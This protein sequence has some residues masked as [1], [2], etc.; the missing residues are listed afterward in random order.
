MQPRDGRD[1]PARRGFRRA[2][3]FAKDQLRAAGGRRGFAETEVL[4]RWP[5]IVGAALAPLCRPVKVSYGR[6]RTLGATL[7]VEAEGARAPELE[8]QAPRI[9]ERVNAFY[10]YRAISKL[11]ITQA[12][13][14]RAF[15]EAQAAFEGPAPAAEPD[16]TSLERAA[17]LVQ[18]VEN[19][20]LRDALARFGAYVI[21]GR[22]G[23]RRR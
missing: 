22:N 4:L 21:S 12:T 1:K 13:G 9:V 11:R 6:S 5:E 3:E 16:A 14:I 10:G 19:P 7:V 23:P 8:M 2:G 15:A 20:A 18:D 17:G